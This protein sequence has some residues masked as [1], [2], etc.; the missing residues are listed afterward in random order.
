MAVTLP[1]LLLLAP[2]CSHGTYDTDSAVAIPYLLNDDSGT[3]VTYDEASMDSALSL[4]VASARA[5]TAQPAIAAYDAAMVDQTTDCPAWYA[6]ATGLPYWY[7][8]CVTAA[9]A[10]FA[11]YGE[12]VNY[13]G[14]DDGTDVWTGPATYMAA[15]IAT[16]DGHTFKGSG[17]A[18]ALVGQQ[19]VDTTAVTIYYSVLTGSYAW[20]GDSAAGT[21]L[22]GPTPSLTAWLEDYGGIHA[23]Y[24]SG[25]VPLDAAT[26]YDLAVFD[27]ASLSA[28]EA[29][30]VCPGEIDGTV[31]LHTT[32][33]VWYQALFT[34]NQADTTCDQCGDVW[35]D[36]VPLG[37]ACV[38]ATGWVTWDV[39]PW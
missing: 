30:W 20:D 4:A 5:I 18:Y 7:D 36:G 28:P 19:T 21:W 6:D 34:G 26:G 37:R 24:F 11:G 16:A 27:K 39:A 8:N 17:S 13:D 38:D 22:D 15:T 10:S 25:S 1:L 12:E 14:Y 3:A 33:G 9:G 23:A 2:G 32:D 35:N 31:S 29:G